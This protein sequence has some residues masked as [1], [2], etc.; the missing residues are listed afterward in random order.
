M[1]YKYIY[2]S[3]NFALFKKHSVAREYKVQIK[4]LNGPSKSTTHE[5]F[6]KSSQKLQKGKYKRYE[7]P[8]QANRGRPSSACSWSLHFIAST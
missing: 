5:G 1:L 4:H 8:N 7:V 6:A 3:K 2:I